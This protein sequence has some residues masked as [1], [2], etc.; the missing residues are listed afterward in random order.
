M[1][2][3][4]KYSPYIL[5]YLVYLKQNYPDTKFLFPSGYTVFGTSYVVNPNEH[6][7]GSQLLRIL[8]TTSETGWLHLFRMT[9]GEEVARLHGRTLE[10][11]HNVAD[12]LNVTEQTAMHYIEKYVPQKQPIET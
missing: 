12:T 3:T 11:L 4:D 1:D 7:S 6:L 10:S 5:R 8:K 2:L 9:K